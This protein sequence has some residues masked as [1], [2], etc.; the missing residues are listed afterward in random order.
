MAAI[1]SKIIVAA[2]IAAGTLVTLTSQHS[3]NRTTQGF[4]NGAGINRIDD[5]NARAFAVPAEAWED[6]LKQAP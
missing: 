6:T 2:S 4:V 3:P 5:A 1:T